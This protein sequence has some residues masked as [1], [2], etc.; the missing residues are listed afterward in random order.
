MRGGKE[1]LTS[2]VW[3]KALSQDEKTKKGLY[4]KEKKGIWAEI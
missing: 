4:K 2:D 1:L 3:F